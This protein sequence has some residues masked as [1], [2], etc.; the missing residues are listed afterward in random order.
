MLRIFLLL[1]AFLGGTVHACIIEGYPRYIR[2]GTLGELSLSDVI[3]YS[4]CRN[5]IK[6]RIAGIWA[7]SSGRIRH[8]HLK[9]ILKE[10]EDIKINPEKIEFFDLEDALK[11]EYPLK[12]NWVFRKTAFAGTR[13]LH[14]YGNDERLKIICYNCRKPGKKVLEIRF[15]NTLN[16]R[17]RVIWGETHV[18][19]RT[20]SLVAL[21]TLESGSLLKTSDFK[22][23]FSYVMSEHD[24]FFE[25]GK[26]VLFYK[27]NKV[28][29]EGMPLRHSDLSPINLV[30]AGKPI[31]AIVKR[32]GMKLTGVGIPLK[33]GKLGE[34]I[35]IK[36]VDGKKSMMAR[37]VGFNE[38]E[39][40]L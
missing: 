23:Q 24:S 6:R 4:D 3:K 2:A 40:D 37:V 25:N 28:V 38:V 15:H 8:K 17:K 39:V 11:N 30:G 32:G 29:R 18:A 19:I 21:R 16:G 5:D 27:T 12:K 9:N 13:Q 14:P 36:G 34:N 7:S 20:P 22:E 10:G 31:K 26:K 1:Q 33:N 35:R